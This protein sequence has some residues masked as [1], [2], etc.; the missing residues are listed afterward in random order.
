MTFSDLSQTE[1]ETLIQKEIDSNNKNINP[2]YHITRNNFKEITMNKVDLLKEVLEYYEY[3]YEICAD[4][5]VKEFN[6]DKG[7]RLY[8]SVDEAL[9]EWVITMEETNKNLFETGDVEEIYNTWSKEQIDFI[10]SLKL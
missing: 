2:L 4:S 1:I 6:K 8:N 10:K 7:Y 3:K 9:S 5:T